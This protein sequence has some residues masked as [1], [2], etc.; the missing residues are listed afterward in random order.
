MY[1]TH[2]GTRTAAPWL[3]RFATDERQP[4]GEGTR[5]GVEPRRGGRVRPDYEV[6]EGR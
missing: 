6:N 1:E 4:T 3:P 2:I 5:M